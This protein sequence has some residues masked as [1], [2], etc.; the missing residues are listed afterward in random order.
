MPFTHHVASFMVPQMTLDTC[1]EAAEQ[2]CRLI[3]PYTALLLCNTLYP[4]GLN[5]ILAA[6]D[7]SSFHQACYPSM[8]QEH[9]KSLPVL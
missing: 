1:D 2:C 9:N 7:T 4:I 3:R 6:C 8:H 5:P